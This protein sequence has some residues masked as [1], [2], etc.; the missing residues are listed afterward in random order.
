MRSPRGAAPSVGGELR[1]AM[2]DLYDVIIIGSGPAGYTAALYA[3]RPNL[4]VLQFQ[5]YNVGGQLMVTS[6]VENYPGYEEGSLGPDRMEKFDAQAKRFGT[7]RTAR[8]GMA[9]ALS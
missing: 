7:E 4:R 6:D 3:S 9:V 5:G 2:P 1:V 8:D